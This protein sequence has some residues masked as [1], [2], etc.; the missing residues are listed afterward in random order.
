MKQLT[1]AN[2]HGET[3]TGRVE[4]ALNYIAVTAEKPASLMHKIENGEPHRTYDSI[5]HRVTILDGRAV[6]GYL[7]P[8][9][10]GFALL[11]HPIAIGDF[12]DEAQVRGVYYPEVEQLVKQTTRATGHAGTRIQSQRAV[13]HGKTGWRARRFALHT[14]TTSSNR[15]RNACVT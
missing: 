7:T 14:M 11:H 1:N 15:A 4:A 2:S 10:Q 9:D 12:Y 13:W 3:I 6:N 8:D 5:K